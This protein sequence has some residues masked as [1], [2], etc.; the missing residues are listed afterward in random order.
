MKTEKQRRNDFVSLWT[1]VM[2][3]LIKGQ[4]TFVSTFW[5]YHKP[6][7]FDSMV[8]KRVEDII[9]KTFLEKSRELVINPNFLSQ[10]S[11][12]IQSSLKEKKEIDD[13]IREYLEKN[14]LPSKHDVAKILQYQQRLESR[15]LDLEEALEDLREGGQLQKEFSKS[16]APE[17]KKQ[18]SRRRGA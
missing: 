17:K 18:I 10:V 12:G 15:I 11:N 16:R 5:N 2:M 7:Y 8:R 4:M 6:D 9:E 14:H 1:D 3:G 13:A